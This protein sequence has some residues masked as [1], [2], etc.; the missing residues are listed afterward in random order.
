M[1]MNLLNKS[2]DITLENYFSSFR[3]QVIGNNEYFE[4]P[5]GRKKIVYADWIS[6]GRLYNPIEEKLKNEFGP[7]VGNTHTETSVTGSS[8]TIAYH[9][10]RQTIKD[11]VNANS[12]DIIITSGSGMTG[13]VNK[14][15]RIL[16]I[17]LPDKL[18]GYLKIDD[19]LKPVV[20]VTHM[21]HHSNH[22]SWLET[23]ADVE[24]IAP[25]SEGLVDLNDF[26]NL[27]KKYE[28]RKTKIAAV[29]A[30]SNVTGIMNPVHKIAK[31]IH[32]YGG[33]CFVDYACSAPYVN[34]NMHPEDPL[35]KLDAIYFSP[36]KFLG[37]PGSSGVL[38]FDSELYSS[39]VP[40]QPGGG[41]VEWT[42]PWGEHKY[43][44][45]IESREDGGTPAFLQSIKAALC[46]KLKEE[47][48]SDNILKREEEMLPVLFNGLEKIKGMHILANNIQDR[49]CVISFFIDDLHYNLCVKLLND[50][51]GVQVRG[52]CSCA[53]TYG[54]YLLHISRDYSNKLTRKIDEGDLSSKPGWVRLSVHPIM[55]DAEIDYVLHAINE[56]A[57][58]SKKWKNDYIYNPMINEFTIKRHKKQDLEMQMVKKWF[59]NV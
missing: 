2:E 14:F 1:K 21:E 26:E 10:A 29:S 52:G 59:S 44:E 58:K 55:T 25:T 3:E 23:I 57:T 4:S 35:E 50:H 6:S 36:H 20:F 39:K 12:T 42:N 53:G 31:L 30:C 40:D 17:K 24:C 9:I 48:G 43:V 45:D 34:I 22:T 49:L 28:N 38:I 19:E 51:F 13:V 32:L 8:M 41:T 37:G 47:M 11:H 56:V 7:F 46:V 27:I 54:H 5:Y 18:K 16:G 15:Q 33:F